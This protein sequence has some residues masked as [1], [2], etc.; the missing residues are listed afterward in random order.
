MNHLQ[1]TKKLTNRYYVMRHGQS[2]ANLQNIIVSHPQNGT[3]MDYALTEL[4]KQQAYASAK[5]SSLS[6]DTVIYASDFSRA[7]ETAEIVREVLGT[8]VVHITIALRERH[9][10]DWEKSDSA[11]YHTVWASDK[12][13]ADHR[14]HNVESVNAVLDRVTRFILSL[15]KRY[16]D[17]DIL[18]VSHGD[19]LQILQTAFENTSP[20]EHRGLRHLETAEIRR[21]TLAGNPTS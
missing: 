11:N 12:T 21:M 1:L 2:K 19:T 15:E 7:R 10:G 18:L 17:K 4:G 20:T 6:S 9:F 16:T 14:E 3:H 13:N 5:Q 8:P